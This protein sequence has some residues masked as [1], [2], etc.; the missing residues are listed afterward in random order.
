MR[1]DEFSNL[2]HFTL[3]LCCYETVHGC[4]GTWVHEMVSMWMHVWVS[5]YV[6]TQ[7]HRCISVWGARVRIQEWI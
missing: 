5:G 4:I 1:L 6:D 2:P 7:A 3:L